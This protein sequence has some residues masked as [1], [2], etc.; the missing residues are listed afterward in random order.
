MALLLSVEEVLE[1]LCDNDFSFQMLKGA[2]KS[3][4]GMTGMF[5]HLLECPNVV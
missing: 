1:L 4:N 2:K 5:M 3:A